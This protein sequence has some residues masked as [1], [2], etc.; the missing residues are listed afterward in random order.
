MSAK[1]VLEGRPVRAVGAAVILAL[2]AGDF[3][4]TRRLFSPYFNTPS[5]RTLLLATPYTLSTS[6]GGQVCAGA[7]LAAV[8]LGLVFRRKANTMEALLFLL[9]SGLVATHLHFLDQFMFHG[10]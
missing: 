10:F 7:A 4:L 8:A 5:I 3:V 9:T 6:I 2:V 1:D